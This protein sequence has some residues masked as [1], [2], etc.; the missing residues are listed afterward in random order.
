MWD[1]MPVIA[2]VDEEPAAPVAE[3]IDLTEV[4][5]DMPLEQGSADI[6]ESVSVAMADEAGDL[7]NELIQ[8]K[9]RLRRRS[10]MPER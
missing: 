6:S 1:D 7:A 3:G 9:M 2:A 8:L 4:S 10:R 5:E